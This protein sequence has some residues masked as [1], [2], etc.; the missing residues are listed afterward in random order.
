MTTGEKMIWSAAYAWNVAEFGSDCPQAAHDAVI[1]ARRELEST[2]GHPLDMLREMVGEDDAVPVPDGLA[3]PGH[4]SAFAPSDNT[5]PPVVD[6][7]AVIADDRLAAIRKHVEDLPLHEA[8]VPTWFD[9]LCELVG[10]KL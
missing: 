3:E 10:V 2:Y 7:G 1:Q 5:H 8:L 9:K 4:A 6:E